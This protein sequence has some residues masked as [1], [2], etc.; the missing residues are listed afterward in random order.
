MQLIGTSWKS[1]PNNARWKVMNQFKELITKNAKGMDEFK[2]VFYPILGQP[3]QRRCYKILFFHFFPFSV[4]SIKTLK[5]T[6]WKFGWILGSKWY[7]SF[8]GLMVFGIFGPSVIFRSFFG[9]Y[10]VP[11]FFIF[12]ALWIQST[13][14]KMK[15][16]TMSHWWYSATE[17]CCQMNPDKRKCKK[18]RF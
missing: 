9:H 3:F 6:K 14:W 4:F 10:S 7:F 8:F 11:L 1:S 16:K 5:L 12:S 13:G 2:R 15:A 17:K 18:C